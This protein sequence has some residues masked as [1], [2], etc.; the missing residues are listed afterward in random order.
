MES[1]VDPV[2][3]WE[4]ILKEMELYFTLLANEDPKKLEARKESYKAIQDAIENLQT[5]TFADLCAGFE[6][7]FKGKGGPQTY[8]G[9]LTQLKVV[10]TAIAMQQ[11][12]QAQTTVRREIK[13][14][15][16]GAGNPP[17]GATL[18]S[19][20]LGN[21]MLKRATDL[22]LQRNKS[23]FSDSTSLFGK[24]LNPE[25]TEEKIDIAQKLKHAVD[26][27]I[28]GTAQPSILAARVLEAEEA[29][30]QSVK[31]KKATEGGLGKLIKM[32]TQLLKDYYP[33]AYSDAK[34]KLAESKFEEKGGAPKPS[35]GGSEEV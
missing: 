31:D 17:R 25:I 6:R 16:I 28:Q 32:A 22:Q 33:V 5:D 30:K 29:N 27:C 19:M 10:D 23:M 26:L 35:R 4:A 34:A 11:L 14:E 8:A 13:K 2:E 9:I 21:L 15:F 20:E 3:R 7:D 18:L 12:H 24:T 1:R